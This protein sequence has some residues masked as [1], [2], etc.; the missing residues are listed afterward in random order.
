MGAVFH[1]AQLKT[2]SFE[3]AN[4]CRASL[5]NAN[6]RG[7]SFRHANLSG[8]DLTFANLSCSYF[9]EATIFKTNFMHAD[10]T[11]ANLEF[12]TFSTIGPFIMACRNQV[13][14]GHEIHTP[15]DWMTKHAWLLE[16][17][18]QG[19]AWVEKCLKII[20]FCKDYFEG[21]DDK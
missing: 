10:L 3:N 7:A 16:N 15:R 13:Q 18:Q 4:L 8:T 11:D 17:Y 9:D 19:P 14:I 6:L 2:A 1:N 12:C 20:N 21:K 5:Y